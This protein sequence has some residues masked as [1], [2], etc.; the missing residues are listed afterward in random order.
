MKTRWSMAWVVAKK[1][2]REFRK[3]K[4][5][6]YTLVI[7]PI[8]MAVV[9]PV[10]S[11]LPL[12]G[13]MIE[14][15]VGQAFD[16]ANVS[17]PE[18][19]FLMNED[20]VPTYFNISNNQTVYLDYWTIENLTIQ[21]ASIRHAVLN[22][23]TIREAIVSN[24]FLSNVTILSGLVENSTLLDTFIHQG[25]VSNCTGNNIVLGDVY[26]SDSDLY[27]TIFATR[28][29]AKSFSKSLIDS[30]LI[31]F[32]MIPAILPT[33]IASYS[34]I[35]EKQNKSLEPLLATPTSDFELLM[36]K[37]LS[38]FVPTMISTFI[39]FAIFAAL[40]NALLY[41]FYTGIIVPDTNWLIGILIIAPLFCILGIMVNVIISSKVNDVRASQ[42]LGSLV[43]L[44]IILLFIMTTVGAFTLTP[45]VLLGLA[46]I[47]LIIDI[48][49]FWLSLKVFQ[50]EQILVHWK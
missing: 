10:A 35:G 19:F 46:G 47:L 5:I 49:V 33:V 34:F 9:M 26:N 13:V 28:L 16:Y 4:Y 22:N 8:I 40:V 3:N 23:V 14:Q 38:V 39:G 48:F 18:T 43:V 11:V 15:N 1:D 32:V 45:W 25:L 42:Q 2:L 41:Q 44:P 27:N 31:F 21:S 37:S 17:A 36:G 7:T 30:M 20:Y 24:C 6:L 29:D 12:R 50:R